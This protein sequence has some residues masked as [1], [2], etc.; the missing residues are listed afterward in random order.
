MLQVQNTDSSGCSD[1]LYMT[2][3]YQIYSVIF[4]LAQPEGS[5]VNMYLEFKSTHKDLNFSSH[6]RNLPQSYDTK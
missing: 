1:I 4:L 2:I 6:Q 5:C 3:E